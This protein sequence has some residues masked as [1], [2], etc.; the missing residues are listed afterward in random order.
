MVASGHARRS[1][2]RIGTVRQTSP[3]ALGRTIRMRLG[4]DMI[5]ALGGHEA[6]LIVSVP[7]RRCGKMWAVAAPAPAT[8]SLEGPYPIYSERI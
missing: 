2:A 5:T 4:S 6:T 1:V 7:R 8:A 3:R